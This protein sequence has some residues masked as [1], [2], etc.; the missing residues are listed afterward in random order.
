[1]FLSVMNKQPFCVGIRMTYPHR[2]LQLFPIKHCISL[3]VKPI[4]GTY[5]TVN[6]CTRQT[7]PSRAAPFEKYYASK[8]GSVYTMLTVCFKLSLPPT[9]NARC[10]GYDA[11]LPLFFGTIITTSRNA[12]RTVCRHACRPAGYANQCWR[13]EDGIRG[14]QRTWNVPRTK[15]SLCFGFHKTVGLA[16]EVTTIYRIA[17]RVAGYCC[18]VGLVERIV[19]EWFVEK[20][21]S[22]SNNL[23]V[24]V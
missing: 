12:S 16:T 19:E 15:E 4:R 11:A 6:L 24:S 22:A 5:D 17:E 21:I 1:M 9:E 14:A 18:Q 2:R 23:S 20:T 8:E 13:L 7:K 10:A 3:H